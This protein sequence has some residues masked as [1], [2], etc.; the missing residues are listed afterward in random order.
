MSNSSFGLR[1]TAWAQPPRFEARCPRISAQW[2][3]MGTLRPNSKKTSYIWIDGRG[4]LPS[5]SWGRRRNAP[6]KGSRRAPW[7][8]LLPPL[9]TGSKFVAAPGCKGVRR[10]R[11][12]LGFP[13][14][15]VYMQKWKDREAFFPSLPELGSSRGSAR[16][17]L[18]QVT[19]PSQKPIYARPRFQ[20]F[21]GLDL[22]FGTHL[23][24]LL[25]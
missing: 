19:L 2:V 4:I 21:D 13:G 6:L 14:S 23:P 3:G 18:T 12:D 24:C 7:L 9:P 10:P 1:L 8:C 16:V 20:V 5:S 17:A 15:Y 25:G 11:S 22:L